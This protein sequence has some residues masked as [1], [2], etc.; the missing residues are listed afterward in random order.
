M[1]FTTALIIRNRKRRRSRAILTLSATAAILAPGAMSE[2]AAATLAPDIYVANSNGG[3]VAANANRLLS[4]V[5]ARGEL[6]LIVRFRTSFTAEG[7]LSSFQTANQRIAISNYTDR[8]VER[9]DGARNIKRYETVPMV[10]MTVDAAGLRKLLDDPNVAAIHE[11][12]PVPP[13]LHKSVPIIRAHKVWKNRITGKRWAVAVLDTGVQRDHRSLRR[14][15]LSEA[16]FS[17]TLSSQSSTSVCPGGVQST[18][19]KGSGRHCDLSISGCTHGTHVSGI[20]VGNPTNKYKGVAKGAWLIPIQVFSRFTGSSNCGSSSPCALSYSSD[21]IKGLERVFKLAKKKR[22]A[23][24]NMSLGGGAYSSACDSNSL[25]PAI[26]NLVSRRIAVAIATGNNGYS[27]YIS[28]PACISSAVSV[29]STTKRDRISSFSNHSA[30]VDLMAPGSSIVSSVPGYGFGVKSGTSMATPHVAGAW[31]LLRQAKPK[32]TVDEVLKA[33]ACTGKDV[34]RGSI[35]KPRIDV[36]AA[37]K[38]LKRR[39]KKQNWNFRNQAQVNQWDRDLGKWK[40]RGSTM[41]VN[42]ASRYIWMAATSPFCSSSLEV[43]ANV[44]RI[45]PATSGGWNSGLFLFSKIDRGKNMSGMW[46]AYNKYDSSNKKNRGHAVI[47]R[48][49]HHNGKTNTGGSNAL[50]CSKYNVRVNESGYNFIRVISVDGKHTFYLNNKKVCTA[51]DHTF[52]TGSVAVVMAKPSKSPKH[53]YDIDTVSAKVLQSRADAPGQALDNTP[54]QPLEIPA[55]MTPFG[56]TVSGAG[57]A[58]AN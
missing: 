33:L 54:T 56:I 3:T 28:A 58:S 53:R 49:S 16:C 57:L 39:N 12:V 6:P 14:K 55:G 43:R 52:K 48:L 24:V 15:I 31:A 18:A 27:G 17:T 25:K 44:R 40:R 35:T 13:S 41:S 9:V 8:I 23:A 45:D 22:I 5:Q 10:A 21:Q 50:L 29:G 1:A 4:S 26:D 38:V 11:D 51:V 47:W 42:G 37:Y 46:F 19:A 34:K 32:A 30:L 2:A 7:A 20:A 36:L